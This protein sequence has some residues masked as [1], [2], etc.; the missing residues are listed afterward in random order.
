MALQSARRP[1][2]QN[3]SEF[4]T[5]PSSAGIGVEGQFRASF[6]WSGVVWLA[7]LPAV[8]TAAVFGTKNG[9]QVRRLNGR[10]DIERM[11][12]EKPLGM[13]ASARLPAA[14][15][16]AIMERYA[17]GHTATPHE[18]HESPCHPTPLHPRLLP[19][20]PI[21]PAGN[22]ATSVCCGAWVA[23]LWPKSIWLS[24]NA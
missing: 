21:F 23:G 3:L 20:I 18:V 4:A 15:P 22:W 7:G 5:P 24:R 10:C 8:R 6:A 9:A 16:S 11:I 19:P 17:T 14:V 1:K 2:G 13:T 12:P